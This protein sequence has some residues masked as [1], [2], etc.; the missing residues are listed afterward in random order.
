MMIDE[1]LVDD[2]ISTCNSP[3]V[4][5]VLTTIKASLMNPGFLRADIEASIEVLV[6]EVNES[7]HLNELVAV[8]VAEEQGFGS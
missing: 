2:V 8:L 1:Q 3:V 7:E 6:N 5:L 4:E